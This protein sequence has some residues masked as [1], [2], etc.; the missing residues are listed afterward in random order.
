MIKEITEQEAE[1]RMRV[2]WNEIKGILKTFNLANPHNSFNSYDSPR[3]TNYLLW[4]LLTEIKILNIQQK[5]LKETIEN[6]RNK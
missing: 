6:G 4:R 3:I 5:Q 1:D 2:F